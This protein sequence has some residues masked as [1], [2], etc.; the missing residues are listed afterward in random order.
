MWMTSH[1]L[2]QRVGAQVRDRR[3]RADLTVDEVAS[4]AE[5]SAKT[6]QNLE[7]GRGSTLST[8][9]KVLRAL[10]A[11]HWLDTLAPPEPISPIAVLDAARTT[12]RRQRARRNRD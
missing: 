7:H 11:E 4:R 3:L 5:V 10:D 2:E 6:V 9:I 8:L 12:P 1:E